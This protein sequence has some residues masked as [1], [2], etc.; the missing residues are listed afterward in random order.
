[1]RVQRLVIGAAAVGVLLLGASAVYAAA[2]SPVAVGDGVVGNDAV[3][4]AVVDDGASNAPR[5]ASDGSGST[6]VEPR[7]PWRERSLDAHS[8]R[9]M[10]RSASRS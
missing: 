10:T 3:D 1:M 2:V 9:K 8:A 7:E 4:D 5:I 6:S